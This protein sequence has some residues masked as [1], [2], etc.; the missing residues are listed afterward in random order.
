MSVVVCMN[1]KCEYYRDEVD[2][3]DRTNCR[4]K[5]WDEVPYCKEFIIEAQPAKA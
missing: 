2:K 3:I 4:I 5:M 1:K